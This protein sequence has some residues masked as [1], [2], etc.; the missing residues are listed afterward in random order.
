MKKA[1]FLDRDGTIVLEP[2]DEQVD[3][4]EKLEFYPGVIRN[5]YR[6]VN[7]L[8]YELVMVSNQD[9]LGTS[10]YPESAFNLVQNKILKTL[11][12]EGIFFHDI[13][14]DNS[15][16]H[17]NKNT[18]KPQTGLLLKYMDGSYDLKNSYV[19]GD[20]TTDVE[21]AL[22]LGA[23]SIFLGDNI[24]CNADFCSSDWDEVFKFIAGRNRV[25]EISRKTK[26]TDIFIRLELDGSGF[27]D[28]STGIGFFDHMLDLFGK[29]SLCNL[30]V[31]VKGDLNVDEH[32]SIEDTAIVFGEAV[33]KALGNKR[34]I[35]R[36]GFMLPMDDCLA[37]VALDFSGRSWLVWKVLFKREKIGDFPTEMFYHFFKSFT[38][39]AKCNLNIKATG[40]NEHHKIEGIFKAFAKAFKTAIHK[41]PLNMQ[42][43][44]T[45]GL[46]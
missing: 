1:L 36:Y 37:Q 38:D 6:I 18:R 39:S 27:T 33:R 21:L 11:E 42:I 30:T 17:D 10:C 40:E 8:D 32:H 23:K 26:E 25:G 41:D 12:N 28:I 31:K 24:E 7:E 5:L 34:G 29:H 20:R 19:I 2:E 35:E 22:N 44:S 13:L 14:I 46:L 9:G 45:K 43:P 15:F 3:S 16:P 4:L